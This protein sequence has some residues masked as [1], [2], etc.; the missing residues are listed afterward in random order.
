MVLLGLYSHVER[1]AKELG[2]TPPSLALGVLIFAAERRGM[3]PGDLKKLVDEGIDTWPWGTLEEALE[4][5]RK[6][7]S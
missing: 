2:T 5:M 3:P 7:T 6:E 1:A 4:E